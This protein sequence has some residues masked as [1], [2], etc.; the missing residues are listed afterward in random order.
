MCLI[1]LFSIFLCS[2]FS[3]LSI[4]KVI[5]II[6]FSIIDICLQHFVFLFSIPI[7]TFFLLINSKVSFVL[8]EILAAEE[9]I[10]WNTIENTAQRVRSD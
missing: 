10:V 2:I 7:M 6:Q 1:N 5:I 9:I 8:M 4:L 3:F